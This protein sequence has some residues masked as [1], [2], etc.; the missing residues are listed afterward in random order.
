MFYLIIVDIVIKN[1]AFTTLFDI[2]NDCHNVIFDDIILK[3]IV[4]INYRINN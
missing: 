3:K 4:E 1:F 2:L